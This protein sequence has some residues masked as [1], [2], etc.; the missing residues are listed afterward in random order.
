[1][2]KLHI[3]FETRSTV[4]IKKAGA[5]AYTAHSSTK[6][7]C[8]AYAW[9][10]DQTKIITLDDI[11]KY[12]LTDLYPYLSKV[13]SGEAVLCA[14]NAFFER[15][16]FRNIVARDMLLKGKYKNIWLPQYWQCT[17]AKAGVYGLTGSLDSV[18]S[19]LNIKDSKDK[20]GYRVMMK[21][22]KPRSPRKNEDPGKIYWYED[23]EDYDLL[24]KYCKKDVDIER[25]IDN[26]LPDISEREQ[27]IWIVDQK[28]NDRGIPVDQRK[29]LKAFNV[30]QDQ[31]KWAEN[32]IKR[33]TA[34]RVQS[35]NQ[36]AAIKKELQNQYGV[37][38]E[39]L[40]KQ[41]VGELL[42]DNSIPEKAKEIIKLRADNGKS[43]TAKYAAFLNH[44][45]NGRIYGSYGFHLA[46]TG[47]WG[48]RGIQVH[49]MPRGYADKE[50]ELAEFAFETDSWDLFFD[51]S[52]PS[53][54][55]NIIRSMIVAP[56]E[57]KLM[58]ADYSAI[59][60][61]CLHWLAGDN[62]T[63]E[64]FK[65]GADL[66]IEMAKDIYDKP[67]N[68][69]GDERFVGKQTILGCG[70]GMGV[71]RFKAQCSSYGLDIPYEL[72][73]TCV[74]KY[75]KRF[76]KIPRFWYGLENAAR[77]AMEN[78]KKAYHCG[79]AVVKCIHQWLMIRTP[80]GKVLFYYLPEIDEENNIR[81]YGYNSQKRKV[82]K[83]YTYGGKLVEN[84]T[85]SV[86]RDILAE[87]LLE[88]D[89]AGFDV[90]LHTHDEVGIESS[91]NDDYGLFMDIVSSC[92]EWALGCPVSAEGW[93][94][95]YYRKG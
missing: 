30:L 23:R 80:S 79:K 21:M 52:T 62:I 27:S 71:D 32:D 83:Q 69:S 2:D 37:E 42:K 86:A 5:F 77:N 75:R 1:M 33:L 39:S 19:F 48:S 93:I 78:K 12:G 49:N 6:V 7:Q 17:M 41:A 44:E 45:T 14:F 26:R 36:V 74:G 59:E 40:N 82:E 46:T 87:T 70:Y 13:E 73:E 43:S 22:C 64:K 24:Y 11:K 57:K 54:L 56:G 31:Q 53:F 16:I 50:S 72:A 84:V 68:I 60:A 4:D 15:C 67:D 66:Y 9:N 89:K 76:S 28:I 61:R 38:V 29:I 35:I 92:P 90:I 10:K 81:F 63:C 47:R 18:C 34:F 55:S 85:Q 51:E 3:D 58:V 88:L 65:S 8:L 25:K 94:G 95:K 91:N 20:S